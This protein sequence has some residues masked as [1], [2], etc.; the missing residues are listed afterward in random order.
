LYVTCFGGSP[1]G[2]PNK[3]WIIYKTNQCIPRLTEECMELY[4][5]V[6]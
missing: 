2:E 3:T 5:S 6:N 4:S 1:S